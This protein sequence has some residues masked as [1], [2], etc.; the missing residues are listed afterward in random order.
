MLSFKH[1]TIILSKIIDN[2]RQKEAKS[3]AFIRT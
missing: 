2:A 3:F 1:T